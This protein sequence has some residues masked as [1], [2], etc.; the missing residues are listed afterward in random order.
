[1]VG[2]PMKKK[3]AVVAHARPEQ[4]A[5]LH[6]IDLGLNLEEN[7]E[8]YLP[9]E[10][11]SLLK[12][13]ANSTQSS[14]QIRFLQVQK[15]KLKNLLIKNEFTNPNY[16]LTSLRVLL[17][18]YLLPQY[19]L[20]Q[21]CLEWIISCLHELKSSNQSEEI[22][23]TL[24][25][26]CISVWKQ[27][28]EKVMDKILLWE[29]SGEENF[30]TELQKDLQFWMTSL[31]AL[32][33]LDRDFQWLSIGNN[34]ENRLALETSLHFLSCIV[35]ISS[36]KLSVSGGEETSESASSKS[37]ENTHS[38]LS[39]P[40]L[41]FWSS[42]FTDCM[43][44]SLSFLK[45]RGE[46]NLCEGEGVI[47]SLKESAWN[48]LA[49]PSSPKD[50]LTA[51][52]ASYSLCSLQESSDSS[53][54]NSVQVM[55]HMLTQAKEA[56]LTTIA[57]CSLVR[58]CINLFPLE[59]LLFQAESVSSSQVNY[60]F[61]STLYWGIF[62]PT[63]SSLALSGSSSA[64][65]YALQTLEVWISKLV[66]LYQ[67]STSSLYSTD[68]NKLFFE[69]SI[70]NIIQLLIT[71][72]SHPSRQVSH[73]IPP[74]FEDLCKG[75][76]LLFPPSSSVSSTLWN[77][78]FSQVLAMPSFH[79]GKY[80]ALKSLLIILGTP[81]LLKLQPGIVN[82]LILAM[83]DRAI[84]SSVASLLCSLLEYLIKQDEESVKKANNLADDEVSSP[85]KRQRCNS[86]LSSNSQPIIFPTYF[87]SESRWEL[88]LLQSLSGEDEVL[89]VNLS[90]YLLPP[91]LR[92]NSN[93]CSRLLSISLNHLIDSDDKMEIDNISSQLSEGLLWAIVQLTLAGKLAGCSPY[94][95]SETKISLSSALEISSR[96]SNSPLRFA[97]L[98]ALTASLKASEPIVKKEYELFISSLEYS[99]KTCDV[100]ECVKVSRALKAIVNRVKGNIKIKNSSLDQNEFLVGVEFARQFLSSI[101]N[102]CNDMLYPGVPYD[103]EYSALSVLSTLFSILDPSDNTLV[104]LPKEDGETEAKTTSIYTSEMIND[105]LVTNLL[106]T[107]L[108]SWD[109]SRS[110]TAS[111]M[112]QLPKPWG[113]I[114]NDPQNLRKVVD[115]ARSLAQSAR[116]RESDA[117][118]QIL[119]L[120]FTVYSSE[121]SWDLFPEFSDLSKCSTLVTNNSLLSILHTPEVQQNSNLLSMISFLSYLLSHLDSTLVSLDKIFTII[122]SHAH[123]NS[124]SENRLSELESVSSE[125][126]LAH[127]V[128]LTFKHCILSLQTRGKFKDSSE[129]VL[130]LWR[131]MI[132]NILTQSKESLR[133]A[134]TVVAEAPV[135]NHYLNEDQANPNPNSA[136]GP[137]NSSLG[138]TMAAS[139]VNTNSFMSF[140]EDNDDMIAESSESSDSGSKAQRAIVAAWLLVKESVGLMAALVES[141]PPVDISILKS[142]SKIKNEAKR[143]SNNNVSILSEDEIEII[144]ETLLDSLGR[145]KHMGAI[146]EA[147]VALQTVSTLLLRYGEAQARL[148]G[149]PMKWLNIL[150]KRLTSHQQI[151]ILRRSAG[152]AFSFLSLLR[153]EPLN[154][155]PVLLHHAMK[156]LLSVVDNGLFIQN[157]TSEFTNNLLNLQLITS[158]K[159]DLDRLNHN[160]WKLS[161]HALNTL[162]LILLDGAF[163]PDLD[164]YISD[165]MSRALLGFTSPHWAVRNSSMMVFS[166]A[167]TRAISR[168]K[169]ECGGAQAVTAHD[170]FTRYGD[171]L[172]NF[173]IHQLNLVTIIYENEEYS[174]CD[175]KIL[176]SSEFETIEGGENCL[177]PLL[178]LIAKFRAPMHDLPGIPTFT[179]VL[180]SNKDFNSIEEITSE[181]KLNLYSFLPLIIRCLRSPIYLV[182]TMASKA[183]A[184]LCPVVHIPTLCDELIKYL[185]LNFHTM[186]TNEVH[187]RLQL[188]LELLSLIYKQSN[189]TS[190]KSSYFIQIEEEIVSKFI[191]KFTTLVE[192]ILINKNCPALD[193]VAI[194]TFNLFI[195]IFGKTFILNNLKDLSLQ[196]S[197]LGIRF[198]FETQNNSN[199]NIV[200]QVQYNPYAPQCLFLG[201]SLFSEL[202]LDVY[203][204]N[205]SLGLPFSL[206]ESLLHPISEIRHGICNGAKSYIENSDLNSDLTAYLSQDFLKNLIKSISVE[207]EP[208]VILSQL[209]LLESILSNINQ[210]KLDFNETKSLV[211]IILTLLCDK[212]KETKSFEIDISQITTRVG[213]SV[214]LNIFGIVIN[215][216][217]NNYFNELNSIEFVSLI[218]IMYNVIKLCSNEERLEQ[219]RYSSVLCIKS[220]NIVDFLSKY[221]KNSSNTLIVQELSVNLLNFYILLIS[222]LQD[223]DEDVRN[224][225]NF[226]ILSLSNNIHS[227]P[228]S[229][230]TLTNIVPSLVSSFIV[231]IFNFN[232]DISNTLYNIITQLWIDQ[233]PT[234]RENSF[235]NINKKI[236]ETEQAN[237]YRE[238]YLNGKIY[239]EIIYLINN[240]IKMDIDFL[241]Q[242]ISNSLLHLNNLVESNTESSIVNC[243]IIGGS[244]RHP[245]SFLY[246]SLTYYLVNLLSSSNSHTE[247]NQILLEFNN[248][249]N[250]INSFSKPSNFP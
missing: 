207:Q 86:N 48:L 151:F 108:S 159:S 170:F 109:R 237:L 173:M 102:L 69:E 6:L 83:S 148:T 209:E 4:A 116:L 128:L 135:D 130:N 66:P 158:N 37:N 168:D 226:Y 89:R 181:S 94:P 176:N 92:L 154:T 29:K 76:D 62:L 9:E 149:L 11:I 82:H 104:V 228:C 103:K 14:E 216:L 112:L 171:N 45:T 101:I 200:N 239:S 96:H 141:V 91:L 214:I 213:L 79:R 68:E 114:Y 162:R 167:I 242:F 199:L 40:D 146:A 140:K 126:P 169:S 246:L 30:P 225:A 249:F 24:H 143:G 227:S 115:W 55:Q 90:D 12:G 164:L 166:A 124:S 125:F 133:L 229:L 23:L 99:L 205:L 137:I 51:A 235:N 52:G 182:R 21:T 97:A 192:K 121:L 198:S 163:G 194:N 33:L 80:Q 201:F 120:I 64:Q 20:F 58:A 218:K 132:K 47:S 243:D 204:K 248:K 157:G 172:L 71:S 174:K 220:S 152:F 44:I 195:N 244:L 139:Y 208:I 156:S 54:L 93:L 42:C 206:S 122:S 5:P 144:G 72:W 77:H 222:L 65:L 129:I 219:I 70:C 75:L 236:F 63:I 110:L 106:N 17:N 165:C 74:I 61:L 215:Y 57:F 190:Q 238:S 111:L 191:P 2:K 8:E 150:L 203:I 36:K 88:Q 230:Y 28:N 1:M 18:L 185:L 210:I 39:A 127:G 84:A 155:P 81:E 41:L 19:F 7:L 241:S 245:I 232:K 136:K 145:L 46:L 177:F 60:P 175:D 107:F 67:N 78:I 161:I 59:S 117:G 138:Y 85:H 178:L 38:T 26:V 212:Y 49:S 197:F 73:L 98:Q 234:L 231:E 10:V 153:S 160:E 43:R 217:L 131:E 22:F 223:D 134:M 142:D 240:N 32:A 224:E 180:T 50:A 56:S 183:Y 188:L 184:A 196:I 147:H 95:T 15:R 187:G 31:N 211:F 233:L 123:S 87:I 53:I 186:R 113:G 27:A 35:R 25:S 105:K 16:F 119:N 189:F 202:N 221:I 247:L 34:E 118:A 13:L 100:D 179:P 250:S 193:F 3:Q